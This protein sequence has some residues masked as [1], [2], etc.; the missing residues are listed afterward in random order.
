MKDISFVVG[1]SK[2]INKICDNCYME[3]TEDVVPDGPIVVPE[4][5]HSATLPKKGK[6]GSM[7]LLLRDDYTP[8]DDSGTL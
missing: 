5:N 8:Y 3:Y 4:Q 1:K 6:F 7:P 2:I